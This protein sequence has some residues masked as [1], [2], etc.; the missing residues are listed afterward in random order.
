MIE[1][2][3]FCANSQGRILEAQERL[4]IYFDGAPPAFCDP[5]RYILVNPMEI[6]LRCGLSYP[7]GGAVLRSRLDNYGRVVKQRSWETGARPLHGYSLYRCLERRFLDGVSWEKSGAIPLKLKEIAKAGRPI[8]GCASREDVVKRYRKIDRL[9]EDM[10][11]HGYKRQIDLLNPANISNEI[12]VSIGA[13]GRL[14]FSNG[15]NHR[16]MLAQ[17]LRLEAMPVLVMAR[18]HAW[19][20]RVLRAQE[21]PASPLHRHPDIAS[22]E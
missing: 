7:Q 6:Q 9:Y 19:V 16:I 11:A 14:Y 18:D 8:D 3:R 21:E 5:L 17:I 12:F 10:R 1:L 4:R 15:G 22:G 2:D 20:Q 13:S